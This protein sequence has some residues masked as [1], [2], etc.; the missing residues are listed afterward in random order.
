[1]NTKKPNS[2]NVKLNL[3]III[4]FYVNLMFASVTGVFYSA[5]SSPVGVPT[6]IYS[7]HVPWLDSFLS[8]ERPFDNDGANAI[9]QLGDSNKIIIDFPA[10][11]NLIDGNVYNAKLYV[12]NIGAELIGNSI[13]Y[14]G[15]L[16]NSSWDENT[17]TWN[18]APGISVTPEISNTNTCFSE[19]Y[20]SFDITPLIE[21]YAADTLSYYGLMLGAGGDN[22]LYI[23]KNNGA[24]QDN[25]QQPYLYVICDALS[26]DVSPYIHI[27]NPINGTTSSVANVTISGVAFDDIALDRVEIDGNVASGL[28]NWQYQ[29]SGLA[30][31]VHIVEAVAYDI[32]GNSYTDTVTFVVDAS[33]SINDNT[34][35]TITIQN[36]ANGITSQVANITVSGIAND[37]VN[38]SS[39][40]VNGQLVNGLNFWDITFNLNPGPNTIEAIAIDNAGNSA[41]DTI[42]VVYDAEAEI[43][44]I[45]PTILIL[46]PANGTVSPVDHIMLSGIA[47]DDVDISNVV[48]RNDSTASTWV[49][50]SGIV[51]WSAY[52]HLIKGTNVLTACATD[53]SGNVAYDSIVV[54]YDHNSGPDNTPPTIDILNP[55][56]G[57]TSHV[58]NVTISGI[59]IDD[60]NLVSVTVNGV[61]ATGLSFWKSQL[62]L[63]EGANVIAATAIDSSGN[64]ASDTIT[65][66][67]DSTIS[68]DTVPPV[69][70]IKDP[71]DW[72][73]TAI[74]DIIVSGIAFDDVDLSSV[75]INGKP[76]IGLTDW[77]S[78]ITLN[79]GTNLITAVATDNSGN[80]ASDTIHVIYNPNSGGNDN[81]PW[82]QIQNPANGST[83]EVMWVKV[84]GQATDDVNVASVTVNG[85]S[86][87]GLDD[88]TANIPL[89]AG[90]NLITAVVED[91][92]G[93]VSSDSLHVYYDTSASPIISITSPV[94]GTVFPNGSDNILVLGTMNAGK[95]PITLMTLNGENIDQ[96]DLPNWNHSITLVE[97]ENEIVA[98]VEDD[99]GLTSQDTITV[100][101]DPTLPADNQPPTL[102][103]TTP[104]DG[105]V[106]PVALTGVFDVV[107]IV[108][109]N[110]GIKSLKVRV[111]PN[112]AAEWNVD[113][114]NQPDWNGGPISLDVGENKIIATATDFS[115]N[116]AVAIN[117]VIVTNI[118][119]T[120]DMVIDIA[121]KETW[122]VGSQQT[123]IT[124]RNFQ[125][126]CNFYLIGNGAIIKANPADVVIGGVKAY[127][128]F[129]V[130]GAT[131]GNRDVMAVNPD[132]SWGISN[133]LFMIN[134]I[135]NITNG[136]KYTPYIEKIIPTVLT[137]NYNT[138]IV[139]LGSNFFN[140]QN[141][142]FSNSAAFWFRGINI[143]VERSSLTAIYC[144]AMCGTDLAPQGI[145]RATGPFGCY[146]TAINGFTGSKEGAV[147]LVPAIPPEK[148]MDVTI[149]LSNDYKHIIVK[150]NGPNT[151]M[152]YTNV[153]RYYSLFSTTNNEWGV[154][155]TEA[156]WPWIIDASSSSSMYIHLC[157]PIVHSDPLY[158]SDYDVGKFDVNL[159][160]NAISWVAPP[161]NLFDRT[162]KATFKNQLTPEAAPP[163]RD[164]VEFQVSFG[165]SLYVASYD[166]NGKFT[167]NKYFPPDGMGMLVQL[168]HPDDVK[169]TFTGWVPTNSFIIG[170]LPKSDGNANKI[171][172]LNTMYPVPVKLSKS[173]FDISG[174]VTPA[175]PP[176]KRDVVMQKVNNL[177][178]MFANGVWTGIDESKTLWP[179]G[180]FMLDIHK[181]HTGDSTNWFYP[182]PY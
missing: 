155:D 49:E 151:A 40:T 131:P 168:K 54:I 94:D 181:E 100:V 15:H 58:A 6:E 86:A 46:N 129:N 1:M 143:D 133:N 152:I 59:A 74:A 10:A 120:P 9:I 161:F 44:N 115:G 160:G 72:S 130:D 149:E 171:I 13:S 154:A 114:Y 125:A 104:A 170:P 38:L 135:N 71:L 164:L 69:I 28:A 88:W 173:G 61:P 39:V 19:S 45:L 47:W 20:Q 26:D 67:Y 43:D 4:C 80:T 3:I 21:T 176:P 68:P 36:P 145:P 159:V 146:V 122:N 91:N 150:W 57:I 132:G 169:L 83:T 93:N 66:Y 163:R 76:T 105:L 175:L 111:E 17:V 56:D 37:D 27:Q 110:V 116:V 157:N 153:S 148:V 139:I 107:G 25:S 33:G 79:I 141:I 106:L 121:P 126:D 165:E 108:S 81:N 73:V 182:K 144:T 177:K 14:T 123:I 174:V 142:I 5:S 138:E 102:S 12:Y 103:I 128:L 16:V 65:I 78:G 77:Q 95:H 98:Y 60:V 117:T 7:I 179:G 82:I 87:S 24:G 134:D 62:I 53:N 158:D 113:L 23:S 99:H 22:T 70:N 119:A 112:M 97:G 64:T 41:T 30:D 109:D 2:R 55:L 32:S 31:G 92:S 180:M 156:T 124:G 89:S 85:I 63:N 34:P 136:D 50:T 101:Y 8:Y 84:S 35:P 127:A 162:L 137:N 172:W 96:T 167:G 140:V 42:Y 118:S 147:T 18:T 90:D 29:L 178:A 52:L 48:V 51:N 166:A 11:A 75:T